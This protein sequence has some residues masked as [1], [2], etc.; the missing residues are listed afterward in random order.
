MPFDA[1][2]T[3]NGKWVIEDGVA[4]T[5]TQEERGE[6]WE[7]WMPHFATCPDADRFRTGRNVAGS[8]A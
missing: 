5:S 8:D 7:G 4:R 1:V 3:A 2:K 6:G